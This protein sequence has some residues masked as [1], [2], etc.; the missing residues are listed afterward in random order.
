MKIVILWS[1]QV[2]ISK[3]WFRWWFGTKEA[4]NYHLTQWWT[5][6]LMPQSLTQPQWVNIIL[7][8][9]HHIQQT[10]DIQWHDVMWYCTWHNKFEG[11]TLFSVGTHERQPYL[12]LMGK[13][14]VSFVRYL[15][16]IDHDISG[17]HC[18]TKE[19]K[20]SSFPL[21]LE[22]EVSWFCAQTYLWRI[23]IL[24]LET[25]HTHKINLSLSITIMSHHYYVVE[26]SLVIRLLI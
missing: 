24:W 4:T 16:K 3:H 11:K 26:K 6:S 10:L 21:L 7:T 8:Q 13:L 12:A 19:I 23:K 9:K 20:G 17:V 2:L 5:Y 22:V 14:W 15:E 25:K 1:S 18:T